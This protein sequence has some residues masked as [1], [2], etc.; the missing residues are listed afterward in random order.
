MSAAQSLQAKQKG[1][2]V[3][4]SFWEMAKKNLYDY[5]IIVTG[6]TI[7]MALFGDLADPGRTFGYSAFYSPLLFGFIGVLPSF[8]FYS[9]KELSFGSMLL[10]EVLH[11]ILVELMILGTY[12]MLGVSVALKTVL[13]IMAYVFVVYL[14]TSMIRY[15]IDRKT[16]L[17]INSGLKKIQSS[18]DNY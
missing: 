18:K 17:D 14:F 5:F 15:L 6:I 13:T 9:K 2:V 7:L 12:L 10:R 11:L 1:M 16:M 3:S 8:V 4:M